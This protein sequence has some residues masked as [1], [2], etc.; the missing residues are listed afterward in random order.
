LA[1]LVAGS[2][3]GIVARRRAIGMFTTAGHPPPCYLW[4]AP[5][6]VFALVFDQA[7]GHQGLP[8]PTTDCGRNYRWHYHSGCGAHHCRFSF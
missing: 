7:S 5:Y 8:N 3:R 2:R 6:P 4:P 1:Q